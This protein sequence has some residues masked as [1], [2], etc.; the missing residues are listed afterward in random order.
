[1]LSIIL[2]DLSDALSSV[3]TDASVATLVVMGLVVA[4][5]GFATN[6]VFGV[7]GRAA[8]ALVLMIPALFVVRG[9]LPAER[10]SADHWMDHTMASWNGLMGMTGQTMIGHYL[11]ALVGVA[12]VFAAKSVFNRG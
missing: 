2:N 11:V 8:A 10:F 1:M 3:V 7:F 6:S 12:I 5:K 4:A 9:L